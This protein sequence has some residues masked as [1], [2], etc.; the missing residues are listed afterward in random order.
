MAQ[1]MELVLIDE[2]GAAPVAVAEVTAEARDF[3][4]SL[5]SDARGRALI[6]L[7][8]DLP[9]LAVH[10]HKA[11]YVP[12]LLVWDRRRPV[13]TRPERFTLR[14]ERA[15]TIGGLVRN[16]KGEPVEGAK[17][18]VSLRG[19][20]GDSRSPRIES[21]I[22]ERPALT[23]A[24]GRWQFHDAPEDVKFIRVL[25]DHPDYVSLE[26]I[27]EPPPPEKFKAG[28]AVLTLER[29]TPCEGLVTDTEGR[30]LEGVRVIYGERGSG[31]PS[32]PERQTDAEGKF[33]F[34]G[35]AL[36]GRGMEKPVLSFLKEGF[37]PE[38]LELEATTAPIQPKI[39]LRP[40]KA[41]RLKFTDADGI[42]IPRVM[43]GIHAWRGH[44]P[45]S[46][47]FEADEHGLLE[48]KDAPSDGMTFAIMHDSI[49]R[50]DRVLTATGELQ[51]ILLARPMVITGRVVD[52]RTKQ[53]IPAFRVV[54]GRYFPEH[55]RAWADWRHNSP[56]LFTQG[57]YRCTLREPVRMMAADHG[58]GE[59]GC[60][61]LRI[62]ADG[63]QPAVSRPIANEEQDVRIDFELE[64]GAIT[65]GIVRSPDNLPLPG[66][67]VIIA[68]HGNPVFI[69]NG[70]A[71]RREYPGATTDAQGRYELPPQEENFPVA[72][73]HPE[74]GYFLTTCH[75]LA[76]SPDVSLLPWGRLE[77]LST[78]A[79]GTPPAHHIQ[80]HH[81]TAESRFH[82]RS[83]PEPMAEGGWL[84][85]WLCA[86]PWRVTMSFQPL[87]DCPVVTILNGETTRLDLRTGRRAVIGRIAMPPEGLPTSR[88]L[89]HLRVRPRLPESAMPAGLDEEKRRQW[90]SVWGTAPEG[91][92]PRPET[93][94]RPFE[95]DGRGRFR[96]DELN[97][98]HY[99][100]IGI[101]H[102]TQL[103]PGD[104]EGELAGLVK[105]D[106]ELLPGEGA[107]D[108]G[109][110]PLQPGGRFKVTTTTAKPRQADPQ[111]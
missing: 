9:H 5:S 79:E 37:A 102:R 100:L 77:I 95:I 104:T 105:H 28:T 32:K 59:I 47:A 48:W 1:S 24:E 72:I 2:A 73:I 62:E 22:W 15:R 91:A 69:L 71:R 64:P 67:N 60:H 101:F 46:L 31:S 68:G 50:E 86:G 85:R 74:A 27:N 88:Q 87:E 30:P 57:E 99:R 109:T 110:L 93:R 107:L 12:R 35:L 6:A 33:R 45:F 58:P 11:G 7:P 81:Q 26:P 8:D 78:K 83:E 55:R 76:E 82:F 63:Y 65:R 42:T 97:F 19:A 25:L 96:I 34:G 66:A 84:Y 39:V 21:D 56:Q 20:I 103:K 10:V 29:G 43:I 54:Q 16:A 51:T 70:E 106:F 18:L 90:L 80:S 89:A 36:Q 4:L 41:L 92:N 38:L 49:Q 108:L 44:R 14:M 23:D 3:K 17:V 53:P 98:G 52:A 111:S 61:R 94:E 40:G 13:E 75:A